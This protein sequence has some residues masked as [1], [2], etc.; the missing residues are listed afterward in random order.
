MKKILLFI[1]CFF[2]LTSCNI[3][4]NR[5]TEGT[6]I[7]KEFKEG[8][9]ILQPVMVNKVIVNRPRIIPDKW[10]IT[11]SNGEETAT[12]QVNEE[13]YNTV[14]IGYTVSLNHKE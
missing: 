2:S 7:A 13:F 11:I 3:E 4:D 1:L 10:Y 5:I 9:T 6:V 8:Y 12:H 14:E